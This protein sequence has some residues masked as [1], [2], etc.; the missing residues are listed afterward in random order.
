MLPAGSS[1]RRSSLTTTRS[2]VRTLSRPPDPRLT[3]AFAWSSVLV[4]RLGAPHNG[5]R[6]HHCATVRLWKAARPPA[7]AAPSSGT[8]AP[9]T[10]RR[11]RG[12]LPGR[13]P[14]VYRLPPAPRAG[15]ER[16]HPRRPRGVHRQPAQPLVAGDCFHSLQ[17]AAGA[18]PLAGGRRG[19]RRQPDGAHEATRRARQAHP[20]RP[21]G[22]SAAAAGRLRR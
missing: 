6:T 15:A 11:H 14:S 7:S 12:Q 18:V 8:C 2:Q 13:R 3:C 5:W 9:R 17:A 19:D 10:C 21:G 16:G 20:G 4:V 1:A 22:S